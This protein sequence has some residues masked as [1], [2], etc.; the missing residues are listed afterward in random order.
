MLIP[1]RAEPKIAH[2]IYNMSASSRREVTIMGIKI[3]TI[4]YI[5]AAALAVITASC[6]SALTTPAAPKPTST[7]LI[8]KPDIA[9]PTQSQT[10]PSIFASSEPPDALPGAGEVPEKILEEV[11]TDL[12]KRSGENRANIQ[13]VKVE[14]VT[15][16]DG[17]LGCPKEGEVY[18]Q[19]L[20]K[21]YWIV[22]QADG[23]E[24]DYRA[25]DSGDFKLCE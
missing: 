13:V 18:I 3:S 20:I 14:A 22:L 7:P 16:N 19:I 12:I 1:K 17:S 5:L 6:S 11:I 23:M 15:W 9:T 2:S 21:G 8:E 25:S 24:Y 4:T 10:S